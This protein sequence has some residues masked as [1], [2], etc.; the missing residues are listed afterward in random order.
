MSPEKGSS[1]PLVINI[2]LQE[3]G[4]SAIEIE[5]DIKKEFKELGFKWFT[6]FYMDR[7]Q[8]KIVLAI[9]NKDLEKH[10]PETIIGDL[11]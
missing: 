6:D 3:E 4:R 11:I 10:V 8:H 9:Y 5:G 2:P 1:P 7:K